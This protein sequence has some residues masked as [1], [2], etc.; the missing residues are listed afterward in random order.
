[1]APTACG[2]MAGYAN[3]AGGNDEG[4]D[5]QYRAK[6]QLHQMS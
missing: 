1:L 6:P 2:L 4:L 3:K 5:S